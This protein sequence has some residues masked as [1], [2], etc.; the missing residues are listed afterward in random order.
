[1][2]KIRKTQGF[3]GFVGG[4]KESRG[5]CGREAVNSNRHMVLFGTYK[6][7]H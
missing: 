7:D 3:F 5:S 1:M 2:S 4:K 6:L